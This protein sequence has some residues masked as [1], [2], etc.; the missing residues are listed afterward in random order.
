[1]KCMPAESVCCCALFLLQAEAAAAEEVQASLQAMF[2]WSSSINMGQVLQRMAQ[3]DQAAV[4]QVHDKAANLVQQLE[5]QLQQVA[6]A[7][8]VSWL[9]ASAFDTYALLIRT[10]DWLTGERGIQAACQLADLVRVREGAALTG[11]CPHHHHDTSCKHIVVGRQVS[12]HKLLRL[13]M[14]SHNLC[15]FHVKHT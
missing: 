9:K 12:N 1:M 2:E 7:V 8:A 11:G 3:G 4:Q 15:T 14:H 10:A 5:Q 13:Q 6:D